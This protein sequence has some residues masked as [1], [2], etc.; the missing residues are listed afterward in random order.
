M[1]KFFLIA[2]MVIGC[3]SFSTIIRLQE[4]KPVFIPPSKQ[5]DGDSAAGYKYLTTGD[6]VKGGIPY[7][8]FMLGMGKNKKSYLQR[9]GLNSTIN[10]DYTVVKA[11][12][13]ENLVAPNC[14]QCHAQIFDSVLYIGLGNTFIDFSNNP[15]MNVQGMM[16]LE[17][18]LKKSSPQKY[19]AALPFLTA[20]KAIGP[21]LTTKVRGVNAADRLAGVLVAHR[22]PE[23]FK[24]MGQPIMKI[25]D[26]VVP[27]DTPAWWLLK[28]KNGM[29]YNGFGRGDFGR[30]LMAS[31]L[32]TV[33]DTAESREV[34]SHISNVLAYI[35]SIQP[36]KYPHAIDKEL[37]SD[38]EAIFINSCA[39]CHG[40]YGAK[41]SYPNLLIPASVI[42]TDSLL[43][44]SN[45]QDPQFIDWFN[46]SWF[47]KGD[48]PARL[49][50]YNG[51]IAP[52]LDGI[53]ITAP[54]FHNGSVPTLEA[55]LNSRLRPKYWER[56]F[57][58]PKYDYDKVGWQYQTL[59]KPGGNTVYNTTL[60]G[61]GNYGHYFGDE[62]TE[63]ERTAVLE[64]L[65][66]L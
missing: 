49:Q 65:K 12:N 41:V 39:K 35:R 43:F 63:V 6:Y 44:K 11:D 59:D 60:A 26:E 28:K 27:T 61:Y 58:N 18:M 10:Y 34:D 5:R 4:E 9:D 53:W 7:D 47:T 57:N 21:Y 13:G 62:L 16:M 45:Y 36:P 29:F 25:P 54:F 31:N 46:K 1:T 8:F 56:D 66:T 42:K 15:R 17:N 40:E 33:N 23:T 64:Y 30:F 51:Y 3:F 52:P 2:A 37:A 14:M 48:H 38:G 22:D 50:P 20:T 19:A 55:V 24:W 32:L